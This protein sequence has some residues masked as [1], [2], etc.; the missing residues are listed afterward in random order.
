MA[1]C[2]VVHVGR[3][4]APFRGAVA[5]GRQGHCHGVNG[6]PAGELEALGDVRGK[7]FRPAGEGAV[8]VKENHRGGVDRDES[9]RVDGAPELR[10]EGVRW[11]VYSA[12][13]GPP[14]RA[15]RDAC[16]E[17][18]MDSGAVRDDPP[19]VK[20]DDQLRMESRRGAHAHF[21]GVVV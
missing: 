13:N 5:A 17:G 15:A 4:P 19:A 1:R 8:A 6:F 21:G 18:A 7:A 10:E 16:G 11:A 12:G 3:V 20:L 2:E 14:V 9:G